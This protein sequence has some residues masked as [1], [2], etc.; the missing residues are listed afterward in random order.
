LPGPEPLQTASCRP[1]RL[2]GSIHSGT[3]DLVALQARTKALS[4]QQIGTVSS[5]MKQHSTASGVCI[6]PIFFYTFGRSNTYTRASAHYILRLKQAYIF[7]MGRRYNYWRG[8]I[9]RPYHNI[10]VTVS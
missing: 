9:N 5:P 4:S 6:L 3:F 2:C 8:V 1:C 7:H 10:T